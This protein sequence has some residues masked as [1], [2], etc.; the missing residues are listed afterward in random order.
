MSTQKKVGVVE[1]GGGV[2]FSWYKNTKWK[3]PIMFVEIQYNI[4]QNVSHFGNIRSKKQKHSSKKK[5]MN[6]F[7]I[8][9]TN[10]M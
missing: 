7:N 6:W 10:I 8:P 1:G 9:S 3:L 5:K 2:V 4:L